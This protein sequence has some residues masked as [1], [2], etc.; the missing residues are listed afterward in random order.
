[1]NLKGK[2]AIVTGSS[3]GLG[4]VVTEQLLSKGAY[5]IGWSRSKTD[6]NHPNFKG[7]C[8]DISNEDEVELSFNTVI[9]QHQTIDIIINN[10]GFGDYN[11]IEDTDTKHI[12][13]MFDTNVFAIYLITKLAVPFM[14]KAKA[15][16]IINISSIAGIT[17]IANMAAYNATKFAVKGMSESLFKEL[18]P[19][20]IK[21]TCIL[22]GSIQ[23]NFFDQ[24]EEFT[25][26]QKALEASEVADS[27]LY[28][29]QSSSTFHPVN[30]EIRPF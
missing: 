7:Y 22:P 8:I 30:L 24:F 2:T 27:I 15:G 11:K 10:A 9:N 23:T 5:V 28:C 3:K 1:M 14:K 13:K 19:F 4:K 21:V 18:R 6:I 20:D 12:K 25:P 26:N 16:H 29:L 17:G